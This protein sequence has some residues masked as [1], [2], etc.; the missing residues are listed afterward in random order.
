MSGPVGS[1]VGISVPVKVLPAFVKVNSTGL[2]LLVELV[3]VLLELVVLLVSDEPVI[4]LLLSSSWARAPMAV[5]HSSNKLLGSIILSTRYKDKK[6]NNR[7]SCAMRSSTRRTP[8][9][10]SGSTRSVLFR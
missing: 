2:L 4:E 6:K 5:R 7:Q 8:K 9:G 3:R 10:K 1:A